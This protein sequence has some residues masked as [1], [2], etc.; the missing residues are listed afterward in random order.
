MKRQAHIDSQKHPCDYRIE[1][2]RVA[3]SRLEAVLGRMHN[4]EAEARKEKQVSNHVERELRE[5]AIVEQH[6]HKPCRRMAGV[7][8][9]T[10]FV[11]V[12]GL[13]AMRTPMKAT[14]RM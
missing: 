14:V 3:H 1:G 5:E 12:C 6:K 7:S 4:D 2:L 13:Q 8:H 11:C 9:K 10:N